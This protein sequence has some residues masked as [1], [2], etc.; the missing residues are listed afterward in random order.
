ML[1]TSQASQ[2]RGAEG[3]QALQAMLAPQRSGRGTGAKGEEE[4]GGRQEEAGRQ[5][6]SHIRQGGGDVGRHR[7]AL[8]SFCA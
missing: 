5:H 7:L 8:P 2:R 3:H 4:Y 1:Y 6:D